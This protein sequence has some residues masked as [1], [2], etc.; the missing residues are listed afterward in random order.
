MM[1][2]EMWRL[3]RIN[4]PNPAKH[5]RDLFFAFYV[6]CFSTKAMLFFFFSVSQHYDGDIRDLE[7][8]FS[9]DED[10][11]GKVR[12]ELFFFKLSPT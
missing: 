7:L 12:I 11:L 5:F 6:V 2:D 4:H 1:F 3:E 8:T 10:V 9:F